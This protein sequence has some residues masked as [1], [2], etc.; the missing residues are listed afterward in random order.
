MKDGLVSSLLSIKRFVYQLL[1][2]MWAIILD[3]IWNTGDSGIMKLTSPPS[4][5]LPCKVKLQGVAIHFPLKAL[6]L[7]MKTCLFHTK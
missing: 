3:Q 2:I 6:Y 7:I 4:P 5:T 1:A